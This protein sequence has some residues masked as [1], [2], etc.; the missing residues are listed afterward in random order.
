MIEEYQWDK[1]MRCALM[2][3]EGKI[4]LLG[5]I[6]ERLEERN[7]KMKNI[8]EKVALTYLSY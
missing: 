4:T 5:R 8:F 6:P 3:Y 7:L 2:I 1:C